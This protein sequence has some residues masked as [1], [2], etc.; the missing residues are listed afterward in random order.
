MRGICSLRNSTTLASSLGIEVGDE[1]E[2]E[3][4]GAEVRLYIFPEF[5]DIRFAIRL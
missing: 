4:G 1:E 5:V 2:S 3:V